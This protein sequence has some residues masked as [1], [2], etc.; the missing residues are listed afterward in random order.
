MADP[1]QQD[2]DIPEHLR[3]QDGAGRREPLPQSEAARGNE[4]PE[5]ERPAEDHATRTVARPDGT[6]FEV[7]EESGAAAGEMA[8][9]VPVATAPAEIPPAPA[10]DG[11]APVTVAPMADGAPSGGSTALLAVTGFVAGIAAGSLAMRGLRGK[12]RTAHRADGRDDS[13]SFE[14]AIADEGTIPDVAP[15]ALLA[16]VEEAAGRAS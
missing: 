1:R 14:A 7:I 10:T 8:A 13:R 16:T 2:G 15:E 12:A 9:P 4:A 3:R 5:P 6:A 11:V